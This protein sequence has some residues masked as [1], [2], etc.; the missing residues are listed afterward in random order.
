MGVEAF[1]AILYDW[2]TR[3]AL[4]AFE[5]ALELDPNS[6]PGRGWYTWALLAGGR[7]QEAVEQAR[8]IVQLDPQSP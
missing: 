3:T 4:E 8:R 7:P 6:I 2:D 1:L 5:R